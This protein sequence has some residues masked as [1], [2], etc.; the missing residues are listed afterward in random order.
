MALFFL[1][2]KFIFF[3]NN[4][5]MENLKNIFKN[6]IENK[7]MYKN[8]KPYEFV[9]DESYN[10]NES[11]SSKEELSPLQDTDE[12]IFPSLSIN[13]EYIQ[14]KYNSLIN[15]DIKLR[16]FKVT[17]R[18]K[19]YNAL[20]LYIDGMVET[21]SIN[22]FV[23]K[24][25][26]LRNR[27]NTFDKDQQQ[28]S[29]NPNN[30]VSIRKVKKFDLAEAI[31]N[32]LMPQNDVKKVNSFKE[33]FSSVNAGDCALFVDTLSIAFVVDVKGFEK[34]SIS[35]PTN[36]IVIKGSQES[37]IENLRTNT[38]MLRKIVNNENLVIEN[39]KVGTVSNTNCAICY[40]KGI[41]NSDLIAEVKYRINNLSVDYL[42][43]SGQL[44]QLVE[45]DSRS[46]LPQIISTERP[47]K[48][49][50]YLLEGRVVVILNGSPYSL[51]MPATFFDFMIT[52][53]DSN[54]KYQFSNIIKVV[55]VIALVI[56]ILLPSLYI[57][58]TNFHQEL[59]PTELLFA[60]VASRANV[61]F[62]ILFEIILMEVSLELI[63]EAGIRVP[64]PLGQTIGIVGGIILSDAAVSAQI[65]SPIL[66]IIVAI[67]AISNFTIPDF[68]L[69]F[70]IR[71][72][73]FVYII[74]GYFAG[75]LGVALGV[76]IH[77][78]IL[79]NLKSFGVDYLSPYVPVVTKRGSGT[80]YFLPP[81]WNR[82]KRPDELNTKRPFKEADISM[83]W[84]HNLSN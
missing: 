46:S 49:T 4:T 47:D 57:S 14:S 76:F 26:M 75:F 31:Y 72:A 73:R 58:A 56:S 74:L 30:S 70:H 78:A 59:L 79:A 8:P 17:V 41:A 51:V 9:L 1:M 44:E 3:S 38:S 28:V 18:N 40:I 2:Y 68:S 22:D 35:P 10:E 50:T 7:I 82:E 23:L 39:V 64:S 48:A 12:N 65:V 60:I 34:R 52:T 6:F 25:L 37:F 20:L 5:N 62:P 36:E 54:L 77:L 16:E 21:T 80:G 19:Q 55:R 61:P 71:L 33:A 69:S 67:T 13:L 29:T 27:A 66:I 43:S 63:R 32:S 24:P 81:F 15:S 42:I 53:E 11:M 83:K 45:D 84:K